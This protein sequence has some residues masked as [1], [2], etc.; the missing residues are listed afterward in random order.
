MTDS[1]TASRASL[2]APNRDGAGTWGP[3]AL[4]LQN[5]EAPIILVN[6]WYKVDAQWCNT[7]HCG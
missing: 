4:S 2:V 1:P 5:K 6:K 3:V 7:R